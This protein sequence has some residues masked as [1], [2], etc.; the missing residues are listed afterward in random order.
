MVASDLQGGSLCCRSVG[1][2]RPRFFAE[3]CLLAAVPALF[4]FARLRNAC[5]FALKLIFTL[6]R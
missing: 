2:G 6:K 3:T 4:L 1:S 5:G